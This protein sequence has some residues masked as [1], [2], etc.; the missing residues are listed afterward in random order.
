MGERINT[1][2]AKLKTFD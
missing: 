2:F 1:L